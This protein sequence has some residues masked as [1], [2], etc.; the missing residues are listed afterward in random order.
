MPHS[1]PTLSGPARGSTSLRNSAMAHLD[2]DPSLSSV[3]REKQLFAEEAMTKCMSNSESKMITGQ[4]E[5]KQHLGQ[6]GY[7][8][9]GEHGLVSKAGQIKKRGRLFSTGEHRLNL[10]KIITGLTLAL[11][12]PTLLQAVT[13]YDQNGT[14]LA[15]FGKIQAVMA[16]D[17]AYQ[18]LTF[19]KVD[20]AQLYPNVRFGL[21]GRTELTTGLDGIMLAEW[22]S[23]ESP[24][25]AAT[26][27]QGRHNG[28]FD[29]TRYLF[30]GIDAYQYGTLMLGRGDG[31]YYT[32]AG[33]TDIFNFMNS[34][35]SDYYL[36]GAQRPAAI[37][38]SLRAL[39][40]DLKLSYMFNN[41]LLGRTGL[42]ADS[43]FGI[44]ISSK[45][46][47][48][49]TF[50]YGA[51]FYTFDYGAP[52]GSLYQ[53][54]ESFFAPMYRA[55]HYSEAAAKERAHNVHSSRKN[56]Y[57]MALSYGVADQGLYAAV[58]GSVSNYEYLQ[59]HL[60]SFD[61][62]VQ[63]TFDSGA[64]VALGYGI[65]HYNGL[66]VVSELTMGLSYKIGAAKLFA[67]AQFDLN[68]EAD[69]FYSYELVDALQLQEDKFVLGAEINF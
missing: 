58:V 19:E 66:N 67:E 30:V 3:C 16:N 47:D 62:A 64:D 21:S 26:N 46:G 4:T 52:N 49:I 18:D 51:D 41:D 1:Y 36:F 38:Y 33:A 40:W 8:Q 34:H 24:S 53:H 45:F 65:K 59:H 44:S 27:G 14:S 60:Y 28:F 6:E 25:V 37:M 68:S 7:G 50:A 61:S 10:L 17:A 63:Y 15:L 48:N 23:N 20:K 2:L 9:P 35:A 11:A 12:M 43:G 5:M 57:G 55:D 56:E 13:V 39:S 42:T 54:T 69:Q 29:H 22:D 32:V 31:A